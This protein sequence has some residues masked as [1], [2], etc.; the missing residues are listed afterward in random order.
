MILITGGAGYIGSHTN[1]ELFR[2]GYK[3][4]VFDNLINGHREFVKWGEFVLGDLANYE[5]LKLCFEKNPIFA[6]LH[7]GGFAYV[8]ESVHNPEKYYT[9]NLAC[10]LNLLNIMKDNN[11]KYI[12]FSSSCTTYGIPKIIPITE[13]QSKK[14]INPY[15]KSKL[16][17][18]MIL[19]DYK[20]AYGIEYVILRYFNA[21]G[22]DHQREI[23]ENHNPETHLIPLVLETA[24]GKRDHIEIYGNSYNTYDGTCI[25]DYVHVSDIA[26]AHILALDY[27]IKKNKSD[28]F[29]LGYGKG[30]SV[31]EVIKMAENVTK[32]KIKCAY[33]KNRIG[34]PPI[35]VSNYQKAESKLKWS[36]KH[37]GLEEIIR[38]A[39]EWQQIKNS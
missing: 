21:A 31:K 25:R 1:K 30:Y 7:L 23:G 15:G 20:K 8:G 14:P 38:T 4:L 18:E 5:Q 34:D 11:V 10:T 2:K 3:T 37:S 6:V 36:P 39:W 33:G 22:S 12:V 32:R 16:M 24:L 9:N 27:L 13:N 26:E 29:N 35:L 28:V 19:E 17:V